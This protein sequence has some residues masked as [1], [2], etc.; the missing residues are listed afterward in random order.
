[1]TLWGWNVDY[2]DVI[3]VEEDQ[4]EAVGKEAF[5]IRDLY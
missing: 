5:F 4:H 1:M 2:K 3:D